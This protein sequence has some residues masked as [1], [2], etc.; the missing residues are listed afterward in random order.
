MSWDRTWG[1]KKRALSVTHIQDAAQR[2]ATGYA[3]VSVTIDKESEDCITAFFS[4]PIAENSDTV[5]TIELSIYTMGRNDHIL[6]L[7]GD[8][9]DNHETWDDAS[10]LA[11]DLAE[12]LNATPLQL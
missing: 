7:E 5:A 10:Q 6:S 3:G 8:A 9:A 1:F 11:E 2:V 12:S 4:V